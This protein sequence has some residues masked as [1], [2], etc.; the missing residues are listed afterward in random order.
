M[1]TNLN[2]MIEQ[3]PVSFPDNLDTQFEQYHV[4]QTIHFKILPLT[5]CKIFSIN[6]FKTKDRR[7]FKIS[8]LLKRNKSLIIM[9][10]PD[11]LHNGILIYAVSPFE[12]LH[13]LGLKTSQTS[14]K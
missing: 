7:D 13:N 1:N 14:Q 2:G 10:T 4:E 12:R 9:F 3:T 6:T 8:S 11:R 5:D